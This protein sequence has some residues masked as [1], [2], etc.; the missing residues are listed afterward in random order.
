MGRDTNIWSDTVQEFL[1]KRLIGNNI[2]IQGHDFQ[3]TPFGSSHRVCPG[4]LLGLIN[5]QFIVAQLVHCFE[6][7]LPIGM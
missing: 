2:D 7:E 4:M 3:L 5:I 6:W 1:P